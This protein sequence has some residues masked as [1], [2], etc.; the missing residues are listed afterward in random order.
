MKALYVTSTLWFI[1]L[2]VYSQLYNNNNMPERFQDLQVEAI[3]SF[4]L[5]VPFLSGRKDEWISFTG[6]HK[7]H[8]RKEQLSMWGST[9]CFVLF[10]FISRIKTFNQ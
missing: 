9:W 2:V 8:S 10:V 6:A 3:L 5:N 7:D 1:I 4:L